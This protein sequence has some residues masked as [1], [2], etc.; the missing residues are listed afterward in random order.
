MTMTKA[1]LAA[2]I[3]RDLLSDDEKSRVTETTSCFMCGIGMIDRGSRFCSHR[4]RLYYDSGA[5]GYAQDYARQPKIKYGMSMG[6][7]GFYR[8]CAHCQYEFESNGLRCCSTECE[9]RCGEREAN[10]AVMREIGIEP[11]RKRLCAECGAAIPKWR[12][13]RRVSR[14][15]RFCSDR[16]SRKARRNAA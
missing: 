16:C 10:L 1:A 13:G 2:V 5:P 4:C 3:E 6:P 14:A 11:S 15:T 8:R 9:R 7:H 12:N